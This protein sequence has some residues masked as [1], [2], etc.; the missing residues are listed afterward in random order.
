MYR[1]IHDEV[2]VLNASNYVGGRVS[3]QVRSQGTRLDGAP[4]PLWPNH[5]PAGMFGNPIAIEASTHDHPL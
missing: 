5:S 3:R 4:E 2:A 1:E